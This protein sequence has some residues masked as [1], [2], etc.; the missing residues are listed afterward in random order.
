[1]AIVKDNK[2]IEEVM[3]T[4]GAEHLSVSAKTVLLEKGKVADKL[5][6]I[7][8][9]CLRLYFYKEG[10]MLLFNSSLRMKSLHHSIVCI[11]TSPACSAWRVS[12]QRKSL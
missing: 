7:R 9:G 1:M 8:N 5:Y 10:L 4:A 6:M 2:Y 11:I 12:N 3:K